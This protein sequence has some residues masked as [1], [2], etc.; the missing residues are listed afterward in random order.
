MEQFQI[1]CPACGV[2]IHVPFMRELEAQ[3]LEEADL[4][5]ITARQELS[6]LRTWL[7]GVSIIGLFKFWLRRQNNETDITD[8]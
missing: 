2:N 4:A 8:G 6:G 5:E 1:R 3:A 7:R